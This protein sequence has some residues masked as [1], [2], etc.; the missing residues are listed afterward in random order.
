[1][2]GNPSKWAVIGDKKII[3]YCDVPQQKH[4]DEC[5]AKVSRVIDDDGLL[6]KILPERLERSLG[7]GRASVDMLGHE[8]QASYIRS[9]DGLRE[10]EPI[11]VIAGL[12]GKRSRP[13]LEVNEAVQHHFRKSR[14]QNDRILFP[15]H[16]KRST[17]SLALA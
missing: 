17:A 10:P 3:Q 8:D 12:A 9:D 4:F 13:V 14:D 11:Y 1:M 6:V 15:D 5:L 2:F 7:L 16:R